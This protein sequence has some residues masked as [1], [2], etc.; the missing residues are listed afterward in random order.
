MAMSIKNMIIKNEKINKLIKQFTK[1]A[2]VG[3]LNTILNLIL[4]YLLIFCLKN[5]MKNQT[6]LTFIANSVGFLLTTLNSYYLNNKFVF[7]KSRKGNLWPLTK[8]FICYGS[9]FLL[10]FIITKIFTKLV[11]LSVF[12]VPIISLVLTVPLNFLINKFWSFA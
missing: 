3:L 5:L 9:T 1:F 8:T 7:K 12:L 10:G 11:G 2:I 4:T 6:M